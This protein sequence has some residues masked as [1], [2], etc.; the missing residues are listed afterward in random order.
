M[1]GA[2][3]ENGTGG[4]KPVLGM[5][6][7]QTGF[8]GMNIIYKLAIDDGMDLRILT[9]YR[10][11]FATVFLVPLAFL[12]ERKSLKEI[13][14]KVVM[15]SFLCGLFG[16]ALAQNL[17]VV[18]LK[19]TSAIFASAM[20]NLIPA[21]TFI[22][23]AL[24]RLETLTIR[25]LSGQA[26][27]L[28]TLLG[29]GGA[30]ILTFYKGIPLGIWKTH[31]NILKHNNTVHQQLKEGNQV[32][33]SLLAVCCCMCYA[34]YLI[35]QA[36]LIE[37]FPYHTSSTAMLCAMA[38]IQ[39]FAFALILQRDWTQWRFG[40]DIRLLSVSY[41]GIVCSGLMFTVMAWCIKKKGPLF[42]SV[43]NPLMLIIVAILSSLLLDEKLHLGSV[44]G[45]FL[46]VL[47]LYMVLWGKGREPAKVGEMPSEEQ[48]DDYQINVIIDS[49]HEC[50]RDGGTAIVDCEQEPKLRV[51]PPII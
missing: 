5:I 22:L 46:I 41:S 20:T 50:R 12:L 33:G 7:V 11:A 19:L 9:A 10:Y 43:F 23:A 37:T 36:K 6:L 29:V 26:K 18:S 27:I 45:T 42:A 48:E 34:T 31:V 39:S 38:T 28:G 35:I 17:Y 1:G 44:L 16:G 25:T 47:G 14:W 4:L 30:M 24:F 21:M 51:G 3:Q 15:L 49:S 40:W 2:A 8:A 32:I 13:T